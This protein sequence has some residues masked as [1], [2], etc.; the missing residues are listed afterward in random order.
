MEKYHLSCDGI[1]AE[2]AKVDD[3]QIYDSLQDWINWNHNRG[4]HS[5]T[6]PMWFS[7]LKKY[8][9]YRGIKIIAEDA[10]D[11]IDFPH[12]IKEEKYPLTRGE[13]RKILDTCSSKNRFRI[14]AQISSGLRRG[15][16]LRLRKKDLDVTTERITINVPAQITKT[17]KSRITFFSMETQDMIIGMLHGLNDDDFVFGS[18]NGRN[19]YTG[20]SYQ[21]A[22]VN[23]LEKIG[24]DQK[25]SSGTHKISTHSFR[26]FF[27][28]KVSR[29]D[30]NLAKYFAGQEQTGDLLMYDRLTLDEKLQRYIE[31]E[32]DLL[33]FDEKKE[34]LQEREIAQLRT[35]VETLREFKKNSLKEES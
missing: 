11:N 24:F 28:T 30:P 31:F 19:Q 18:K 32:T 5:N 25:Y 26:A 23:C 4:V 34:T 16:L 22:L 21:K 20:S 9:R 17:K 35:E 8:L 10:R 15:E 29:H 33:I 1:I 2:Y 7:Y 3:N 27:I 14:M 6:L 12:K 13:I